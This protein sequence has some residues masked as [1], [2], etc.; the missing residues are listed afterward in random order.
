V[1]LLRKPY[2]L[3][4]TIQTIGNMLERGLEVIESAPPITALCQEAGTKCVGFAKIRM[5]SDE[6]I[7]DLESTLYASRMGI[8]PRR[9]FALPRSNQLFVRIS[10]ERI[11]ARGCAVEQL[12]VHTRSRRGESLSDCRR[13]S[14]EHGDSGHARR[15]EL[16]GVIETPDEAWRLLFDEA[17]ELGLLFQRKPILEA[18]LRL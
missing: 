10:Q 15:H 1:Q 4:L 9:C 13:K 16:H 12:T 7:D 18:R 6:R 8:A 14:L 2:D 5:R 3:P 11:R 17:H